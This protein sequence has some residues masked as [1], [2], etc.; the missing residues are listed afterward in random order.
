M[1][2]FWAAFGGGAAAG[3]VGVVGIM[4]VEWM[5]ATRE[6][7]KLEVDSTFARV[8]GHYA[9]DEGVLGLA[10]AVHRMT[11]LS[12]RRF[13][14]DGRGEIVEG[15]FADL[16]VFDPSRVRDAASFDDP[17]QPA[18]GIPHVFV[19]GTAVVSAGATTGERPGRPL[20]ATR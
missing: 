14:L 20:R 2:V 13:G 6:A 4:A 17:K 8:L 18:E 15:A 9:R 1:D 12:A 3:V 5:R 11:G 7:A 10:E 19:N 16:V